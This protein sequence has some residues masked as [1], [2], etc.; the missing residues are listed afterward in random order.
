IYKLL[1]PQAHRIYLTRVHESFENA[2]TFFPKIETGKW[3]QTYNRDFL[4]DENHN[5]DY[6][7]QV[8]ERK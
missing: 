6:S 2:D 3:Q 1:M 8:W 7:F 5:Y 4:K